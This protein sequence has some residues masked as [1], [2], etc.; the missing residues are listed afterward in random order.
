MKAPNL[1]KKISTATVYGAISKKEL[2]EKGELPIMRV[3]GIA[4]GTDAGTSQ[5]GDW[6]CLKGEFRATNQQG[7]E[8]YSGLAFLPGPGHSLVAGKL[9]GND[10]L[11]GVEFVFDFFAVADKEG[12]AKPSATGYTYVVRPVIEQTAESR[13][14]KLIN[15]VKALE[16]PKEP[17]KAKG[18]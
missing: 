3:M 9:N 8:F 10:L 1:V 12:I 15:Q 7:E 2:F 5:F 18:K 6:E 17:A 13:L 14:G 16:A 4:T 11:Q